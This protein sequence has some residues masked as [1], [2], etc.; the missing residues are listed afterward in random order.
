MVFHFDEARWQNSV[1]VTQISFFFAEIR[2]DTRSHR[3][4]ESLLPV[5][6]NCCN[7]RPSK[8][9]LCVCHFV[10]V[11]LLF[12]VTIF[13]IIVNYYF[14]CLDSLALVLNYCNILRPCHLALVFLVKTVTAILYLRF[15]LTFVS[16]CLYFFIFML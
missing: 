5:Y 4:L 12:S 11:N 16:M 15:L 3:S 8:Y 7:P 13:A 10:L 1:T 9:I 14:G 6:T 2:D